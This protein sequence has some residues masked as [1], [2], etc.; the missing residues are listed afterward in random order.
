MIAA[1]ALGGCVIHLH[2][3]EN[4]GTVK[5]APPSTQGTTR[6]TQPMPGGTGYGAW[7]KEISQ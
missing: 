4:L 7:W 6:A 5:V 2:V 3:A 1:V